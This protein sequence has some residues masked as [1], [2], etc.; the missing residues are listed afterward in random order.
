MSKY[1][2][3]PTEEAA[4]WTSYVIIGASVGGSLLVFALGCLCII[5][6]ISWQRRRVRAMV[7]VKGAEITGSPNY[8]SSQISCLG[9]GQNRHRV[10]S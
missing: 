2:S 1:F 10:N 4:V 5:S 9:A 7:L 6:I 3:S 8:R